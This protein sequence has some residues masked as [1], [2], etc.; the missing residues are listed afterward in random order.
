MVSPTIQPQ[1]LIK[2]I[3]QH[4]FLIFHTIKA[5]III[6]TYMTTSYISTIQQYQQFNAYFRAYSLSISY[7]ITYQIR[8]TETIP[9][10]ISQAQP[11]HFQ[12]TCPQALKVSTPPRT[13]FITQNPLPSFPKSPIKLQYSHI[14]NLS[15]NHHTHTQHLNTQTSQNQ[16]ITLGLRILP[17]P[18]S[19]ETRLTFSFKRVGSYNIKEPKIS[20]F[21][22]IKL[23]NKAGIS[24]SKTW[25]TSRLI[26]W[27]LQSSP[28]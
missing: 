4:A 27:V 9:Q 17:H 11:E 28:R 12:T 3:S 26:V 25:F 2:H 21:L 24:K 18:R 8:E 22:L 1:L 10:P 14:H 23:E 5:S 7:H 15:H 16:Q 20:T 19:K 13:D 6:I